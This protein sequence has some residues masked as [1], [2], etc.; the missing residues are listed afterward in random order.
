MALV[1]GVLCCGYPAVQ[2][3]SVHYF[4]GFD[5]GWVGHAPQIF[6]FAAAPSLIFG[7]SLVVVA[8]VFEEI[9]FRGT[10]QRLA[11]RWMRRWMAIL[12][13]G[14]LFGLAHFDQKTT[15]MVLNAVVG[16]ALGLSYQMTGRLWVS[17]AIH[18]VSNGA[19]LILLL[20]S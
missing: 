15:G 7:V 9:L 10:I 3:L 2:W 4:G 19:F 14:I 20:Q 13:Q 5:Q 8:P 17:V 1:S 11:G 18:T 16:V 12:L 6:L